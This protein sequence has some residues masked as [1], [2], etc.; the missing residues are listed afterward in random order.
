MMENFQVLK[1][2]KFKILKT[3]ENDESGQVYLVEE[4]DTKAQYA[5]KVS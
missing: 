5:A 3:I 2:E 1:L 4:I